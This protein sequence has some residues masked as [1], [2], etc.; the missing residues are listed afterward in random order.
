MKEDGGTEVLPLKGAIGVTEVGQGV[1]VCIVSEVLPLKEVI[2]ETGVDRVIG[3]SL[4]IE[5]S[6]AKGVTLMT[7]PNREIQVTP[8][9]DQA[10]DR[11]LRNEAVRERGGNPER[12][13][14]RENELMMVMRLFVDDGNPAK[15]D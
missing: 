5:A 11:N 4:G 1:G 7:N 12:E 8:G 13:A 2:E 6:R 10:I 14:H 15:N 3:A 9:R